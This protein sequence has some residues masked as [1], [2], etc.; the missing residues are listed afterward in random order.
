VNEILSVIGSP[1]I[2]DRETVRALV[3][4]A[5]PVA[6]QPK[7]VVSALP[8]HERATAKRAMD[9][10]VESCTLLTI[11]KA[12]QLMPRYYTLLS[13][14]D[15]VQAGV[16][17]I[18]RAI[19]K[20]DPERGTSFNTY[21]GHWINQAIRR[22]I[23]THAHLI[24][25]PAEANGFNAKRISEGKEPFKR[26]PISPLDSHEGWRDSIPVGSERDHCEQAE[27]YDK[28][29]ELVNGLDDRSRDVILSYFGLDGRPP[30]SLDQLCQRYSVCRERARRI[31]LQNLASIQKTLLRDQPDTF[32]DVGV[33]GYTPGLLA[34]RRKP[35]SSCSS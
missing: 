34:F 27:L 11:K 8:E 9:Q 12:G 5:K 25:A 7:G 19:K 2:L 4:K 21:A 14:D 15:L 35:I 23:Q 26:P 18:I 16:K 24:S 10:V 32:G 13:I 3:I 31:I 33:A 22:E 6:D 17:G 20:F 30:Q 1:K 29:R 28:V